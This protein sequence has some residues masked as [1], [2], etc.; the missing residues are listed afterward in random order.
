MLSIKTIRDLEYYLKQLMAD[1]YLGPAM[2][3][4]EP[5]GR[6]TGQLAAD[7]GLS[8]TVDPEVLRAMWRG[9]GPNGEVL[10]RGAKIAGPGAEGLQERIDQAVSDARALNPLLTGREEEQIAAQVRARIRRSV[11]AWDW[12]ESGAKSLTMHWAG[13]LA[14][15]KRARAEGDDAAADDCQRQANA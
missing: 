4:K 6:W 11:V 3:G 9:Q 5:P 13:L 14:A 10:R 12:T 1:Y 15:S 8:G 7:L 2:T